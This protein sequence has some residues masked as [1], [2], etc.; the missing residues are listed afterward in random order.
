MNI[1]NLNKLIVET[2]LSREKMYLYNGYSIEG[3]TTPY[4]ENAEKLHYT[5]K[6]CDPKYSIRY[7]SGISLTDIAINLAQHLK[8]HCA[9]PI[10]KYNSN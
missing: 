10:A 3:Y 1:A 7:F 2:V 8:D 5:V 9:K 6:L 4:G